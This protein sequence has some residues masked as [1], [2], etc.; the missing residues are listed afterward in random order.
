MPRFDRLRILP[1]GLT[2]LAGLACAACCVI[3]ALLVAG[4]LGG[5]GWAA[6]GRVLPGV[7][8]A[9]TAAAA[10]AWWWVLRRRRHAA[11]CRG[12]SDCSCERNAPGS[13]PPGVLGVVKIS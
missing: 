11:G 6:A 10:G 7:A 12:G 2:G 4:V 3:P 13:Q 9:L 5:A 8:I 1:S